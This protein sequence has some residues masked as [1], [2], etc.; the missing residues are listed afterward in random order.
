MFKY[1]RIHH[2][3]F[4]MGN[5]DFLEHY[6]RLTEF[7]VFFFEIIHIVQIYIHYYYY[8]KSHPN[9]QT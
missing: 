4:F 5:A 8:E 9:Y 6:L 7:F 3:F 1:K 2:N